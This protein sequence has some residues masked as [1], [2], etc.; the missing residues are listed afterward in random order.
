MSG[1]TDAF[2]HYPD[3]VGKV[4]IV[5][6]GSKGI[7]A[8]TSRRLAANGVA[9][10]VN[11]RQASDIDAVVTAIGAEG[12]RAV[13]IAADC[14]DLAALEAMRR[15]AEAELGPVDIL[16]HNAGGGLIPPAPVAEVTEEEWHRVV[17][18]NLTSTFLAIKSVLPG[19][20]ERRRGAIVTTAS[21]AGRMP[22][23]APAPLSAAKGAVIMLTRHVADEVAPLGIRVN[24]V[25]PSAV[26]TDRLS[27]MMDDEMRTFYS[28]KHPLGRL[29]VPDDVAAATL[30]LASEAASWITGETL[31]VTGGRIMI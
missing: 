4:A 6:G 20:I 30:F 8:A 14:T 23:G 24:C 3:L 19:M 26:L 7:G 18:A 28:A 25:S 13:G 21:L 11:G 17:D 9:V 10:V 12:G 27:S 31:D 16:V 5:T 1:T 29:G 2:P 15:Q 22:I